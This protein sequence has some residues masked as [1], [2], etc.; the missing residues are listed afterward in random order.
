[1]SF[2]PLWLNLVAVKAAVQN[3]QHIAENQ[4]IKLPQKRQDPF[5][6]DNF[7]WIFSKSACMKSF[8]PLFSCKGSGSRAK[9]KSQLLKSYMQE[10]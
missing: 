6:L 3:E 8:S 9:M 10:M 4:I 7:L 1:V 5:V 2:V